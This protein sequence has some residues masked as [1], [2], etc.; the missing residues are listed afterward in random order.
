LQKSGDWTWSKFEE[1]CQ[2]LTRDTNNDG[3]MDTYAM[4]SFSIELFSGAVFSNNAEFI[5]KGDDG[6]YFNATKNPAC[7][8]GLQWAV[9]LIQKGY[10]MPTPQDANWDWFISAFH[11]AKTAMIVSE[12][13]RVGTWKDMK[14]DFGFV[15]FPKGPKASDYRTYFSDNVAVIPSC[16]DAE[17][18]DK[19]AFAYNLY[20][21]PTPGYED[22]D[23]WKDSYYSAFRDER[24]VDE[25][26]ALMYKDGVG[27]V[28]YL[29]MIPNIGLGDIAWDVYALAS[30]PAEKIEAI[31]GTWQAAID[32]ANK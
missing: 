15:L 17:T 14:D 23:S 4:A 19:I 2:K 31:S 1:L 8:E 26:L 7:L 12:E 11:D 21:N 5:G 20:T 13:Y 18:A 28:N 6:K 27:T 16:F 32:E 9:S 10:E 24:A 30:T 22:D 3:K 29:S 25:T